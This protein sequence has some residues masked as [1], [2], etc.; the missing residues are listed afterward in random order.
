[1]FFGREHVEKGADQKIIS[2]V[3]TPFNRWKDAIE[4]FEAYSNIEYHEIVTVMADN[5]LLSEVNGKPE[6]V[7]KLIDSL[8]LRQT[9]DIRKS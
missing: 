5:L 3:T 4:V 1:M 2:L 9:L 8:R 6:S 7:M